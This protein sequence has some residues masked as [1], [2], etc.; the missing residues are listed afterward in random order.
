[1][2]ENYPY[3]L[4]LA[5]E[6]NV[7]RAAEKLHITH[8]A[9]SRY[10]S[11]LEQECGVALFHRKPQFS[12]TPEGREFLDTVR[13]V[14]ALENSLTQ[15]FAESKKE[16]AG[17]I[18][19]GTTEGRFRILMPNLIEEYSQ[20]FPKVQLRVASAN[21]SQ[22]KEMLLNNQL[23]I[24]ILGAPKK[25]SHFIQS[26]LL[27]RE[28]LYLVLSDGMLKKYFPGTYPYCIEEF[29]KGADLRKF[30][31]IPF[32][33]NLPQY[34]SSQ[35]LDRL[36][37]KLKITLNCV[38]TSS[39]PDLHHMLTTENYAAS[40]CLSMYLPNLAKI[41]SQTENKLHAFPIK[42]LDETNPVMLEFRKERHFPLYGE[43]LLR[44]IRKQCTFYVDFNP[45][46]I[47]VYNNERRT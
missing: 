3:F 38:H 20:L 7:T 37:Q 23:D 4:L 25:Q 40:F 36:L 27:M 32:A 21:S 35:M 41:N 5:E 10:L 30:T 2:F 29:R 44:L 45:E 8:Q 34:N 42:D 46:N 12:L 24:I 9:L 18:R 47:L 39:H 11:K 6:N 15:A 14:E 16:N 19:L 17:I 43:V 1:M 31:H 28:V 26:K 22:L 13:Q 33:L